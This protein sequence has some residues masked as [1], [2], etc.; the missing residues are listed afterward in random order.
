MFLET[1][2]TLQICHPNNQIRHQR[3]R[4]FSVEL[5]DKEVILKAFFL[6]IFINV[7]FNFIGWVFGNFILL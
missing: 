5:L 3:Y 1:I 4:V 7:N 2:Q 6:L